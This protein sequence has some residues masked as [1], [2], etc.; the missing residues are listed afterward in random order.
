MGRGSIIFARGVP[1]Q[2]IPPG[3]KISGF[4]GRDHKEDLKALASIRRVPKLAKQIRR[5]LKVLK[6]DS[7]V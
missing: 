4:P 2:S 6:L 3:S 1:T 7:D 5:I